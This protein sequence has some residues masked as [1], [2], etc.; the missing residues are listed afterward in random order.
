MRRLF[1]AETAPSSVH[2]LVGAF[3]TFHHVLIFAMHSWAPH[4]FISQP[5]RSSAIHKH[6]VFGVKHP[7]R[8][9]RMPKSPSTRSPLSV[10]QTLCY[11]LIPRVQRVWEQGGIFLTASVQVHLKNQRAAPHP[12]VIIRARRLETCGAKRP[13]GASYLQALKM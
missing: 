5:R 8:P 6:G 1:L 4:L 3:D 13:C 7:I 11:L 10:G 9:L 12:H 2:S